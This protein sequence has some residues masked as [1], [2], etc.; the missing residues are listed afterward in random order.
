MVS[1][2]EY[3]RGEIAGGWVHISRGKMP[4]ALVHPKYVDKF[5]AAPDMYEALKD[6]LSQ[7]T[8]AVEE[9]YRKDKVICEKASK[10]LA[11]AEGK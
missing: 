5:L 11:K 6:L 7:F 10:A 3:T 4:I 2:E 9:P 1:K 8:A